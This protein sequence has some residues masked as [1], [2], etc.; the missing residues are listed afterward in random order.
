MQLFQPTNISLVNDT[1]CYIFKWNKR[2]PNYQG[3]FK[4]NKFTIFKVA[5]LSFSVFTTSAVFAADICPTAI[6]LKNPRFFNQQ[7]P[8]EKQVIANLN[9]KILGEISANQ[10]SWIVN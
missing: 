9:Q 6:A 3:V 1:L 7:F 10:I 5:I 2:R 8:V 4:V